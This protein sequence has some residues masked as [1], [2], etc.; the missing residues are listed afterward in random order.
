LS[1]S[2]ET[3]INTRLNVS[4]FNPSVIS[5]EPIGQV[6]IVLRLS[7]DFSGTLTSPVLQLHM[8]IMYEGE[9]LAR[10]RTTE[11]VNMTGTHIPRRISTNESL[12]G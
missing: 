7:T 11:R 3:N 4:I 12:G 8:D 5:I 2:N 10:A 9:L 6:P 1:S